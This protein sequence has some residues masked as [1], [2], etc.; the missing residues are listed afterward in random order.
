MVTQ[1]D[2]NMEWQ[3][4]QVS[5]QLLFLGVL[6]ILS[7]KFLFR[8]GFFCFLLPGGGG[9][10]LKG[11]LGGLIN[12]PVKKKKKKKKKTVVNCSHIIRKRGKFGGHS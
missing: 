12:M 2:E 10:G 1:Q 8:P 6:R 4:C 5:P 7:K 11:R 9:R 3:S